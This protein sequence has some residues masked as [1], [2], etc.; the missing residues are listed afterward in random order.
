MKGK[1]L[2]IEERESIE[3]AFHE[4]L[5]RIVCATSTLSSGINLP[6]HRVIIKAQ[7][8]GPVALNGLTYMQMVG[9]AG[10][11]GQTEKAII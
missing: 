11:L 9:R 7:M 3:N 4:Q 8:C 2:T 10:R 6:A 1:R 5:L